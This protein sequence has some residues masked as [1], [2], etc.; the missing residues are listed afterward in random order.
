MSI[1]IRLINGVHLNLRTLLILRGASILPATKKVKPL[2]NKLWCP[3]KCI[4][5]SETFKCEEK[6]V[7]H[8]R[9]DKIWIIEWLLCS[10]RKSATLCNSAKWCL[11][12]SIRFR[13]LGPSAYELE[14]SKPDSL[15]PWSVII[16][17]DFDPQD[18]VVKFLKYMPENWRY[19]APQQKWVHC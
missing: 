10:G 19:K 6:K 11:E 4:P 8:L 13:E 14:N 1:N 18:Q 9:I 15:I 12:G 5:S 3:I 17:L 7:S 16:H 2:P